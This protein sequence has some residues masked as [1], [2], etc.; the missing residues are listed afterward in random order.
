MYYIVSLFPVLNQTEGREKAK[1]VLKKALGKR[2]DKRKLGGKMEMVGGEGVKKESER[3]KKCRLEKRNK[4]IS[5]TKIVWG[6]SSWLSN[7]IIYK[8]A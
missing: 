3:T 4:T 5:K 7:V 6:L 2:V 8:K 1:G